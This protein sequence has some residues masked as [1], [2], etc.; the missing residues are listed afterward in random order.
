MLFPF[1]LAPYQKAPLCKGA[2]GRYRVKLSS[3]IFCTKKGAVV[4]ITRCKKVRILSG[5][6]DSFYVNP[7][8]IILFHLPVENPCGKGCG[9]CGKVRVFNSYSASLENPGSM[10]KT[11]HNR[12]HTY[13]A[14]WGWFMLRHRTQEDPSSRKSSELLKSAVI[15]TVKN[16]CLHFYQNYFCQL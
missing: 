10:W 6:V 14:P 16:R 5:I 1:R 4:K 9:E 8:C 7:P 13:Y 2:F 15:L 11:L 12:L 3:L